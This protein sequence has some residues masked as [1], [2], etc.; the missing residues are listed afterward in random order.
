MDAVVGGCND[1]VTI[2]AEFP[3]NLSPVVHEE[4]EEEEEEEKGFFETMTFL[5]TLERVPPADGGGG[6]GGVGGG[7]TSV[8]VCAEPIVCLW[9]WWRPLDFTRAHQLL[10]NLIFP[11]KI[12]E[13]NAHVSPKKKNSFFFVFFCFGLLLLLAQKN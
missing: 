12:N 2:L 8:F 5:L 11:L 9:G 13:T 7:A 10:R 4:E 6:G 1:L 3:L